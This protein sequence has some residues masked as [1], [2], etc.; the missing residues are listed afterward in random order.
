[1]ISES[2]GYKI[3]M[4]KKYEMLA[5]SLR[6]LE[7][8]CLRVQMDKFRPGHQLNTGVVG[9]PNYTDESSL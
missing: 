9:V 4:I 8:M 2:E 5:L 7:G 1:M 6:I 3:R